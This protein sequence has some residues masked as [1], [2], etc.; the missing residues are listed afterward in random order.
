MSAATELLS[1]SAHNPSFFAV[2]EAAPVDRPLLDF[3]V[4]VNLHYPK[5]RLL[6]D[7]SCRL[8]E[9]TKY[10]PDYAEVHQEQIARLTG[11]PASA[12]VVANGSTEIITE[13]VRAASGPLVT[14]APTFGQWTDLPREH[15]KAFDLLLRRREN[16]FRLDPREVIQH[17]RE[18]RANT[19]ILSNP[20]NP[21]GV[22]MPLHE[23]TF[24]VEA[25]ADLSTI[26]IDESFIDFADVESASSLALDHPNLIVVKSMGKTLGLH[27]VR[28]G[29]AVASERTAA[30]LRRQMPFW[31]IN[32]LAAFVLSWVA[33]RPQALIESLEATAA[34][35]V[36]MEASLRTLPML[37][38]YPSAANFLFVELED[39]VCGAKLRE[40]LLTEHGIFIRDCGNKVGSSSRY[41]RLA[42]APAAAVERLR[43]ALSVELAS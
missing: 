4:P 21:T 43:D 41:L 38:V 17:V 12:I 22:A 13:L 18:I 14:C 27:G 37:Q 42:V 25:L 23:I 1:R 32:G 16:G 30:K 10:Y 31:N 15:G 33:A 11:L 7:A 39:G 40:R 36:A 19:L 35:R 28:L 29:Y 26:I 2:R 5:D 3:C 20:N 9:I 8:D 34:D 24:I 6:A